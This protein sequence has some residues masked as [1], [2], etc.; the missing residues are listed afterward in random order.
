MRGYRLKQANRIAMG[1]FKRRCNNDEW[2]WQWFVKKGKAQALTR[3]IG[4]LRKTRK[5]CSCWMCGRR[6]RYEGITIQERRQIESKK[7]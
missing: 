5:L 2:Y 6:R 1:Q 3:E 4:I 7:C